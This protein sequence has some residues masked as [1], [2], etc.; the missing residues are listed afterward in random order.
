MYS[1]IKLIFILI[2]ILNSFVVN[3]AL[4]NE[5]INIF[6]DKI[7]EKR[8]LIPAGFRNIFGDVTAS[9]IISGVDYKAVSI[10]G[11]L[12]IFEIG[13]VKE[14]NMEVLTSEEILKDFI[15]DK[16]SL[17]GALK[18]GKIIYRPISKK[19]KAIDTVTKIG[20][21]VNRIFRRK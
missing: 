7:N 3:A 17:G 10:N 20:R 19:S 21:F 6:K 8:H 15:S 5:D 18:S 13:D 11:K 16:I 12:E 9:V 14:P 2:V 4:S 1:M